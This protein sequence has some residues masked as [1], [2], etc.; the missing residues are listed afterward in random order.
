MVVSNPSKYLMPKARKQKV[1]KCSWLS[2]E[3]RDGRKVGEGRKK[4]E[5]EFLIDQSIREH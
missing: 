2:G 4:S 5:G 1:D 3:A